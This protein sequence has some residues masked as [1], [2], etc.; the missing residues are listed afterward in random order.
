MPA[1]AELGAART[2][3]PPA[4]AG[5][6]R[7][8]GCRGG[9]AAPPAR[10]AQAERIAPARA[11]RRDQPRGRG[12]VGGCRASSRGREGASPG[13]PLPKRWLPW[14]GWRGPGTVCSADLPSGELAGVQNSGRTE[15]LADRQARALAAR[16]A[17]QARVSMRCLE[18]VQVQASGRKSGASNGRDTQ[19]GAAGPISA[20]R[21]MRFQDARVSRDGGRPACRELYEAR[22]LTEAARETTWWP[23]LAAAPRAMRSR[24]RPTPRRRHCEPSIEAVRTVSRTSA[25]SCKGLS[26][27]VD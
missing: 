11:A 9:G 2:Y 26:G 7:P 18:K 5:S 3:T 12:G 1:A 8:G 14:P 13:D 16:G 4:E 21:S 27:N 19:A 15:G 23:C 6:N 17:L 24:R 10:P 20:V 22:H 25:P